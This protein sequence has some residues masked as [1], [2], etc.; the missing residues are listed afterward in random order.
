MQPRYSG[1]ATLLPPGCRQ[2]FPTLLCGHPFFLGG[3]Q[4]CYRI[5]DRMSRMTFSCSSPRVCSSRWAIIPVNHCR[6][7]WRWF[8][9]QC[10]HL[11][12]ALRWRETPA[13]LS[14]LAFRAAPILSL[15]AADIPP[16]SSV[17]P[18]LTGVAISRRSCCRRRTRQMV[19]LLPHLYH[20]PWLRHR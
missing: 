19:V 10:L 14:H 15:L 20:S 8:E 5:H 16:F 3:V 13:I 6:L 17:F 2:P 11:N 1:A 7:K 9:N 18:S 4:S 12:T